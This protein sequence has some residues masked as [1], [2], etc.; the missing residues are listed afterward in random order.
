MLPLTQYRTGASP[1]GVPMRF[2][3]SVFRQITPAFWGDFKTDHIVPMLQDPSRW[4]AVTDLFWGGG[5]HT[6]CGIYPTLQRTFPH[7]PYRYLF[8]AQTE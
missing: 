5:G 2:G 6:S 4:S 1:T 7:T 3:Q 8:E